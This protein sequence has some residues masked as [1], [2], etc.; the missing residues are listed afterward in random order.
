MNRPRDSG[1]SG[2]DVC[3]RGVAGPDQCGHRCGRGRSDRVAGAAAQAAYPY[4]RPPTLYLRGIPRRTSGAFHAGPQALSTPHLKRFPHRIRALF[5][6]YFLRFSRRTSRAFHPGLPAL[7]TPY[8]GAFHPGPQALSTP[9]FPRLS[10]RAFPARACAATALPRATT[11]RPTRLR[12]RSG[13]SDSA[14]ACASA[15]ERGCS[16]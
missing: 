15:R 4:R 2:G 11:D 13:A 12:A 3:H 8:P 9:D 14:G 1:V 6:P 7:S 5:T 10:L 16:R